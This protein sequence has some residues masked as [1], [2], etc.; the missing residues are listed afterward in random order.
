MADTQPAM[1]YPHEDQ[2]EA[3]KERAENRDM[4]VSEWMCAM[5]EAGSKKFDASVEPDTTNHELREQR[6]ELR[7]ELRE[8]R[9]RI[10]ELEQRVYRCEGD[11]INE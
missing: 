10:D 11:E 3:W 8:A 7:K 1:C 5:I 2:Y 6:N 4:S 9:E